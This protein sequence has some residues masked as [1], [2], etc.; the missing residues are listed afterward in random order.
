VRTAIF[1]L[2]GFGALTASAWTWV[3]MPAG[4]AVGGASLL[5]IEALSGGERS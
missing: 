2:G 3:G 5:I 1:T 4:L